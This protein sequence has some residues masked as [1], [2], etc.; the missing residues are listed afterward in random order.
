MPELIQGGNKNLKEALKKLKT[1]EQTREERTI[2]AFEP[3]VKR[4][5]EIKRKEM[6]DKQTGTENVFGLP[7]RKVIYYI[8]FESFLTLIFA[9]LLFI[10]INS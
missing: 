6:G 8:T 9:N 10:N 2:D 3:F 1:I 7:L 4:E 5:K